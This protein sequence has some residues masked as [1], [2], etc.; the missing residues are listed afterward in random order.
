MSRKEKRL[1][2]ELDK[3]L[4]RQDDELSDEFIEDLGATLNQLEFKEGY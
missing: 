1:L 4:K 3:L 2:E